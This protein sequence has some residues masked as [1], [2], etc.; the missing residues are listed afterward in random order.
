MRVQ[1]MTAVILGLTFSPAAV[2]VVH[3]AQATFSVSGTMS[4]SDNPQLP[5]AIK[6]MLLS[7]SQPL[8]A[9]TASAARS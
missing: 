5:A 8:L 2:L 6:V 1:F 4:N 7:A 9:Y 3:W